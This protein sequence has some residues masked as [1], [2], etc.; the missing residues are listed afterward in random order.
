MSDESEWRRALDDPFGQPLPGEEEASID[1]LTSS[2]SN[3]S[4]RLVAASIATISSSTSAEF[5][6]SPSQFSQSLSQVKSSAVFSPS[7]DDD[8]CE[9]IAPVSV[10]IRFTPSIHRTN[11]VAFKQPSIPPVRFASTSDVSFAPSS[12]PSFASPPLNDGGSFTG[13]K[14]GGGFAVN[15]SARSLKR[16]AQ[17]LE[18]SD[19]SEPAFQS[20]DADA[21]PAAPV[22]SFGGF[23]TGSGTKVTISARGAAHARKFLAELNEEL[24]INEIEL[25]T[26]V[27]MPHQALHSFAT[28]SSSM[29]GGGCGGF[30]T[31]AG[32]AVNVNP[33]NLARA[34]KMLNDDLHVAK[35]IDSDLAMSF[36]AHEANSTPVLGGF[37]TGAGKKVIVSAANAARAAKLFEDLNDFSPS[38]RFNEATTNPLFESQSNGGGGGGFTTGAGTKVKVSAETSARAAKLF[39][40]LD[41]APKARFTESKTNHSFEPLSSIAK[42][43][44]TGNLLSLNCENDSASFRPPLS[45]RSSA[46]TQ[47]LDI[48]NVPQQLAPAKRRK[49]TFQSP[50]PISKVKQPLSAQATKA[51]SNKPALA[52]ATVADI[53]LASL[54]EPPPIN[55]SAP[56]AFSMSRNSIELLSVDELDAIGLHSEIIHMTSLSVITF[57]FLIDGARH[58]PLSLL[59]S[60]LK[61]GCDARLINLDWV[62]NHWRWI[63][64]KLACMERRYPRELSGRCLTFSAVHRQCKRRYEREFEAAQRSCIRLIVERDESASRFMVLTIASLKSEWPDAI[65]DDNRSFMSHCDADG[66]AC[67]I[68]LTDGWYGVACKLDEGLQQALSRGRLK[69]GMKLR[70]FNARILGESDASSPL[71]NRGSY[72]SLNVNCTRHAT[73]STKLG[74]QSSAGFP[75]SFRSLQVAGG[76]APIVYGFVVQLYPITYMET[77]ADQT[78]VHRNEAGET[79]AQQRYQDEC[80]RSIEQF[81]AQQES[82]CDFFDD[83]ESRF[84]STLSAKSSEELMD[85][86]VPSVP[87]AR[88][89]TPVLRV[90]L[91]E[92]I[93]SSCSPISDNLI[94][95]GS[96]CLLTIWRP[97]EAD[98]ET[99]AEGSLIAVFAANVT[100]PFG[101][102]ELRLTASRSAPLVPLNKKLDS[103]GRWPMQLHQLDELTL[104]QEF[105]FSMIVASVS[106]ISTDSLHVTLF[107]ET[108]IRLVLLTVKNDDCQCNSSLVNLKAPCILTARN[109]EYQ[110]FRASFG[111]C[112]ARST[113]LTEFHAGTKLRWPRCKPRAQRLDEFLSNHTGRVVFELQVARVNAMKKG[114]EWSQQQEANLVKALS[115]FR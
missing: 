61:S 14:T 99:L 106:I 38:N 46:K 115:E 77:M 81:T 56:V 112:E 5:Y 55:E 107:D 44:A 11:N 108:S 85:L 92:W 30:S 103:I 37:A 84:N 10:R 36:D 63:V 40:D 6:F 94:E 100:E 93:P 73:D 105:D 53:H 17:F 51:A 88:I 110:G 33:N 3:E 60:L 109:V 57:T 80:E 65:N 87:D 28:S 102:N 76:C 70:I 75:V 12:S 18:E 104:G 113:I 47:L 34:A 15:D 62:S 83:N 68:E 97:S 59:A 101:S 67:E 114:E 2:T 25:Q 96:E 26:P 50:R 90:R 48:S 52:A 16:A 66:G 9:A 42:R 49:L 78:K 1:E 45:I 35:L 91:R 23:M 82:K 74:F 21:E 8:D 7:Q 31:A 54:P 111:L 41:I 69:V 43:K 89:V 19:S 39:E 98:Q 32:K 72:L 4:D 20:L 71:E 24:G 79:L 29:D 27:R 13:F 86:L 22:Q 64:W 95:S 58:G